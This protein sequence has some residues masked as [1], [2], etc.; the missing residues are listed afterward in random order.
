MSKGAKFQLI[1]LDVQMP[2]MDGFTFLEQIR[3]EP[4]L[5]RPAILMLSSLERGKDIARARALGA[6]AYLVKPAIWNKLQAAIGEALAIVGDKNAQSERVVPRQS[7]PETTVGRLRILVAEDNVVNQM[8]A[9]RTL[10]KA[11]HEAIV[12]GNGQVALKLLQSGHFDVVLMDVQM[13][14]MDGYQAT[15]RIRERERATGMHQPIIAMTAHAMKGD[16]EYCLKMGMD[17]Y[18]SKPF[19]AHELSQSIAEALAVRK[20]QKHLDAEVS[21]PTP[22]LDNKP[23]LGNS[24]P[25][26]PDF[27]REL[28][29]MFLED[30]PRLMA[31][32]R[33]AIDDRN[34]SNL[35]LAG[36]TLKGS[37][38][39]FRDQAAFDA[40]FHMERIGRDADWGNAESV[41]TSLTIE[42]KRLTGKLSAL[43]EP[44][45][46]A[47][48]KK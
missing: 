11:G 9:V 5:D 27:L 26:D 14:I 39:V 10:E 2:D 12:A 42:M 20:S 22:G 35:K 43:I 32:I 30:C 40:A 23:L 3:R 46:L 47:T 13:P 17:G 31:S 41:W 36:H 28:S 8:F 24:M 37:A 25:L 4:E 19:H 18:I 7:T 21:A 1:L 33:G 48:I 45:E 6:G 16:H 44:E 15:A 38:G 29:V 34:D